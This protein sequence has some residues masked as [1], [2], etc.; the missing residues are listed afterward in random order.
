MNTDAMDAR[1][2]ESPEKIIEIVEQTGLAYIHSS[3]S[4]VLKDGTWLTPDQW[5]QWLAHLQEVE[6]SE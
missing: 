6:E 2:I 1:L 5:N 4:A 3:G